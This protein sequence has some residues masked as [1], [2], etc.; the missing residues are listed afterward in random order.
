MREHDWEP[1]RGL[2]ERPPVGETVLW[3]GS[4]Q[5][6][7]MARRAFHI[8]IVA[9]YLG[10]LWL[11]LVAS[12]LTGGQAGATP[13]W[14]AEMLAGNLALALIALGLIASFCW[15]VQRTTIYTITNR[16]IVIRFGIALPLTVNVPFA[17]VAGAGVTAGRDG[18]GDIA[19]SLLPARRVSYFIMWPHARPWRLA[20]VEPML[21]GLP[22][23][24]RAAQVLSRALAASAAQTAPSLPDAATAGVE[25]VRATAAA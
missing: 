16:R 25:A 10:A 4:P 18:S 23:A 7:V 12:S 9:A 8:R 6:R 1:V 5:W 11:W 20:R 17:M 21:R 24:V 15:L 3:Q 22:D 13:L 2:P 19:L 14:R